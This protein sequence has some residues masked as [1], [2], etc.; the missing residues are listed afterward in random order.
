MTHDERACGHEADGTRANGNVGRPAKTAGREGAWTSAREPGQ[1]PGHE[2]PRYVED[3]CQPADRF[4]VS[5]GRALINGGQFPYSFVRVK[6]GVCILPVVGEGPGAQTVL[7]RQYRFPVGAWQ[8]ELP[9]GAIDPGEEPAVAAARELAEE[10]GYTARELVDL[11][12]FHPAPRTRP[13]T[14]SS[15]AATHGRARF[16]STRRRTYATGASPWPSWPGSSARES[17]ATAPASPP[18]HAP[19]R[20]ASSRVRTA[21]PAS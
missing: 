1:A 3:E 5:V 15:P 16:T 4:F 8:T 17:S 18:G 10:S 20:G 14:S 19:R 13:S 21:G 7:I 6:P 11:G 2:A 12:P 9:A